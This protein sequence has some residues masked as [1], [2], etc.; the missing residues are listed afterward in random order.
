MNSIAIL[1]LESYLELEKQ[2]KA[3]EP[4]DSKLGSLSD[5]ESGTLSKYKEN[6]RKLRQKEMKLLK[7][8][9]HIHNKALFDSINESLLQFKPYGKDGEPMPWSRKQ[10]KLQKTPI[11]KDI[12]IKKM[13]EIIKHDMFRWSIMQAGTLPRREFIFSGVFDE[14]LFAE[15]RE[16][17]LATL[18]ATEVIENEY[19]WLN[20]DF[21]EAQVRIDLGDMI[22]EHLVT[23]AISL[24][25][26]IEGNIDEEISIYKKPMVLVNN[27]DDEDNDA[28]KSTL[29]QR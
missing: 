28:T 9:E 21:E 16:K 23:E 15:I 26:K 8:C 10:R 6:E 24:S 25:D 2:R 22:L 11:Q 19:T 17:K 12:D 13:F 1:P 14:E 18:L 3:L 29:K 20:Y 5:R 7:E 27:S 4:S